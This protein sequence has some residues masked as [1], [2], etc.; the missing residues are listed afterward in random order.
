MVLMLHV[1][2]RHVVAATSLG[3][4]ESWAFEV[5]LRKK[6]VTLQDVTK[7]LLN[8]HVS[9]QHYALLSMLTSS[10]ALRSAA[11]VHSSQVYAKYYIHCVSKK[12]SPFYFY[13][14]FVRCWLI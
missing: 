2:S 9:T 3:G 10:T 14:N 11:V 13:D 12:T 4:K 8:L 6:R 5:V 1:F 7:G